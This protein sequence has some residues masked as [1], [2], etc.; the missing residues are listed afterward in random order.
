MKL[1]ERLDAMAAGRRAGLAGRPVTDCPYTQDTPN[2][3]ALTLAFVRAYLKVN[4]EA[5]SAV[6]F[7]G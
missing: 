7:E 3:R 2:G 1:R 6:S 4:P 5:A